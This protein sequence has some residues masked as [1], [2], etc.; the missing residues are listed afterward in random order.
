MSVSFSVGAG[1]TT[2]AGIGADTGGSG[3]LA[4]VG[5][6]MLAQQANNTTVRH[7]DP[8]AT[9]ENGDLAAVRRQLAGSSPGG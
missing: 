2:P 7:E 5:S 8:D 6:P 4:G 9:D 3:V 1:A